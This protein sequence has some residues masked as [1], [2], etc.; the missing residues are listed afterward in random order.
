MSYHAFAAIDGNNPSALLR[1]TFYGLGTPHKFLKGSK[2]RL[3]KSTPKAGWIVDDSAVPP[4]WVRLVKPGTEVELTSSVQRQFMDAQ[5]E[6]ATWRSGDVDRKSKPSSG[7][8]TIVNRDPDSDRIE[9][10]E[11]PPEGSILE[12]PVNTYQISMQLNAIR[13]LQKAP[14]RDHEGLLRLLEQRAFWPD[15]TSSPE[16]EWKFL[17]DANRKGA[18]EQRDF[19]QK[20]LAT[21]DF[22]LLEGPPGSGKTMVICEIVLQLILA[23]KRVL[24]CASTHVAVDNVLERIMH[25]NVPHRDEVLPLRIGRDQVLSDEARKWTLEGRVTAERERLLSYLGGLQAPDP[26]QT[27]F[28]SSLRGQGGRS[29]VERMLLDTAN[30]VCGSTIGILQHPDLKVRHEG[31]PAFDVLII[32][33][34][35]K[36]PFQE[37][38]VPALHAK[39]WILVGD[40]RQLSPFVDEDGVTAML[41]T[42]V[43]DADRRAAAVDSFLAMNGRRGAAAI[44]AEGKHADIWRQEANARK[45]AIRSPEDAD[46]PLAHLVVG[47]AA[48]LEATPN[49]VRIDLETLR[50][51]PAQVPTLH[52]RHLANG[53]EEPPDWASELAWRQNALHNLK[54]QRG[55][56]SDAL[57]KQC[58]ALLP[59]TADDVVREAIDLTRR[60]AYPSVLET[61]RYGF[62]RGERERG[63]ALTDGLPDTALRHRHVLLSWQHR[64]HPDIAQFPRA[65]FYNSEAL[66]SSPHLAHRQWGWREEEPRVTWND[67]HGRFTKKGNNAEVTAVLS[68][69][70]AFIRWAA[71]H[72]PPAGETWQVALLTPYRAQERALRLEV[73]N[74]KIHSPNVTI[75]TCTVDR[76]QGREADMVIFSFGQT[77]GMH[78]LRSP[79]RLNVALTRARHRLVLIGHRSGLAKSDG[80]LG[81]LANQARWSR[82]M[83]QEAY[84]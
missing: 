23:G 31:A 65:A 8:V 46:A 9:L 20:A 4:K 79:N 76:F 36:T 24:M 14:H 56:Q 41:D 47:S 21:P 66:L 49:S 12:L 48:E 52:R 15:P 10:S 22:A 77:H 78:F 18:T 33:E 58:D 35:S 71:T 73:R 26:S 29:L 67:V 61:L 11:L 32:D 13:R 80:S 1:S 51:T 38:L 53:G 75:D 30:L 69:L 3:E 16:P 40:T 64:M 50:G 60:V 39:K 70:N 28:L 55:R 44:V 45:V 62:E 5:A 37:F 2:E 17:R 6:S 54:E 59:S 7:N 72:A 68:E 83:E 27:E 25:P 84:T 63:N 81:D 19:A 43:P 42:C 74:R 34:A 82:D 57:R